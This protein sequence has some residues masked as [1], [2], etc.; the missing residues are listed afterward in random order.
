MGLSPPADLGWL[1]AVAVVAHGGVTSRATTGGGTDV[2]TDPAATGSPAVFGVAEVQATGAVAST[3][4][5][6]GGIDHV[7]VLVGHILSTISKC[8]SHFVQI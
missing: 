1:D 6:K 4:P 8:F 5:E 3:H 7:A 2:L